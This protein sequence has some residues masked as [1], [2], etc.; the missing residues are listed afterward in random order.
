MIE[1]RFTQNGF[2][3]CVDKFNDGS[4]SARLYHRTLEKE[5][6]INSIEQLILTMEHVLSQINY[7]AVAHNIRTFKT[8]NSHYPKVYP[9]NSVNYVYNIEKG[10]YMNFSIQI[11]YRQ[12]TTMQGD[13]IVIE[14]NKSSTFKSE[15]D[16]IKQIDAALNKKL[17][18]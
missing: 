3:F 6:G 5:V 13:L 12:N 2:Q 17:F 14:K 7:P 4:F 16:L 11:L 1:P 8:Q 18:Y 15:L 9:D 10:K